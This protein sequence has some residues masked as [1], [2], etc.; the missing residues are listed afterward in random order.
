MQLGTLPV[1]P[2][3]AMTQQ[4]NRNEATLF[5]FFIEFVVISLY[6]HFIWLMSNLQATRHARRV[7]VGG[8]P[9]TA[10]EQVSH[11]SLVCCIVHLFFRLLDLCVALVILT[12]CLLQSVATFFSHVMAAIG[13]NSAGPGMDTISMFVL[14]FRYRMSG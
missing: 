7:Y 3:Q 10:N 1:M 12:Y 6:S 14:V 8:L 11:L 13:G 2:V 4:V 9:P 5:F